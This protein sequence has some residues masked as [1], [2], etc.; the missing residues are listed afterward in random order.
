MPRIYELYQLIETITETFEHERDERPRLGDE[1]SPMDLYLML[2][3]NKPV[4]QNYS[5]SE[6]SW[7][8]CLHTLDYVN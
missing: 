3:R 2:H 8:G 5:H 7:E 1:E 4:K 6:F